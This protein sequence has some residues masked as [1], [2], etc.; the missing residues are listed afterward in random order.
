MTEAFALLALL[1]RS[2]FLTMSR[3]AW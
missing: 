3:L 2:A 1:A